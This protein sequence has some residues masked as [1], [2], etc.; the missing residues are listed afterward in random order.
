MSSCSFCSWAHYTLSLLGMDIVQW[1]W[2]AA[3]PALRGELRKYPAREQSLIIIFLPS[4]IWRLCIIYSHN[5][6]S[7][8][9]LPLSHCEC[10][11]WP[12]E[13]FKNPLKSRWWSHPEGCNHLFSAFD[14]SSRYFLVYFFLIKEIRLFGKLNSRSRQVQHDSM[15]CCNSCSHL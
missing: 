4:F 2:C 5:I 8:E 11:C 9:A 14:P 13:H 7:R 3:S 10:V 15:D 12:S 6:P 1:R